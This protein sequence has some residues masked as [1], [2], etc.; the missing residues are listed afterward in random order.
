MKRFWR[1]SLL[2]FGYLA[3]GGPIAWGA[4]KAHLSSEWQPVLIPGLKAAWT[5]VA[6]S[7]TMITIIENDAEAPLSFKGATDLEIAS[8]VGGLRKL[9]LEKFGFSDWR[10][11]RFRHERVRD[12]EIVRMSGSYRKPDGG[13]VLFYENQYFRKN[14][15]HQISYMIEGGRSP[16][17]KAEA[18]IYSLLDSL[19]RSEVK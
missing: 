6:H 19:G 9:A 16:N 8:G 2:I 10:M 18:D 1:G 11:N 14:R 4:G 5:H 3:F 17:V 13:T 12:I 15:Y 7:G